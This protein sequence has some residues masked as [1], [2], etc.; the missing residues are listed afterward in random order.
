MN[1]WYGEGPFEGTHAKVDEQNREGIMAQQPDSD[2]RAELEALRQ[3]LSTLEAEHRDFLRSA[4]RSWRPGF[5]RK[6]LLGTLPVAVLLGAGGLLYGQGAGDALFIDPKGW[7][8]IGTNAPK[9]T[10]D[11]VGKLNVSDSATLAN[12]TIAGSLTAG[13]L[14]VTKNANL[15]NTT[16]TGSLATT[17]NVGIG[18]R[19]S[20]VTKLDV[21][22]D[23]RSGTHSSA[24]KGLYVTGD[25]DQAANGV[26]FRHSNGTQG[27]GFGYNTIYAA[28]SIPTQ[29]L[30][31]MPKGTT[32]NVGIGTLDPQARLDVAGAIKATSVNGEKPPMVFDVG[33]MGDTKKW[34]AENR[35]IG[36]L[37]GDADGC[38]MKFLF[39]VNN[40]DEVRTISEQI[41][42]EQPGMSSNT[43]PGLR[44]WARQL[45]GGDQ[46]FVL[47]TANKVDIV[48]HPWNWIYVRNYSSPEVGQL[49]GA[50][51][52]YLVQFMTPP[53]VSATVIIYDR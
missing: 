3:R 20:A 8:G 50:F 21:T 32:G 37:C 45:G 49:S 9:V 53:T 42:I 5:F 44:G 12:A 16:I 13:E 24:V 28:G 47:Q 4:A 11:V 29:H 22:Q 7:I 38:T 17:G 48:P 10:L 27:I 14:S 33:R 34:Y 1:N 25:F 36:A 46:A 23:A 51:G 43:R 19:P 41:Y 15:S 18:G 31:L 39:R 30:N 26:E 6:C 35:D 52:G 2:L 40:S